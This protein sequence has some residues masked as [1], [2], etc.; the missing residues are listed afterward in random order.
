[1]IARI[2]GRAIGYVQL[3][4]A[5]QAGEI[6][7]R[8]LYVDADFQERGIGSELLRRALSA[9][10][11][12]AA[13]AVLI[14]VWEKNLRARQ[15]YER[16]GFWHEGGMEPFYLKSGEIDGYDIVLVRRRAEP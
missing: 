5:R 1:L 13:S 16:F 2:A 7:I 12:A 8:R 3:G 11:T 15:L 9:P 10:E 6:E 4:H 14:D